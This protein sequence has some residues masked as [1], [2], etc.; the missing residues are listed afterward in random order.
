MNHKIR[1][2]LMLFVDAVLINLAVYVALLLRF[3]GV[4]PGQYVD[5]FV[6]LMPVITITILVFFT[7][8]KMY[9]RIWEYA[10]I[11]E[12][13]AILRATTY[14]IAFIILLI[15]LLQLPK[16]PRSVYIISWMLIN[17]F[18]GASRI[19]WR[20]FRDAYLQTR[21]APS[22]RVL[23]I[24]AGDAGAILAREIASNP[25]LNLKVAGFIDDDP[26]KQKNILNGLPVLGTRKS[27]PFLVRDLEISEV[28]IAMPSVGSDAI[29]EIV[30]LCKE[31]SARI[32]ILPGIYQSTSKSLLT[33]LRDIK[34]ED[35]L[36]REQVTVDITQIA[37]YISAKTVLVTGA[38]G[39]IGSE[40]CRQI[41]EHSP[42]LLIMVDH[43][44]NN[45]FEIE[46]ELHD[47]YPASIIYP[48][49]LDIR[50]QSKLEEIF[51]QYR[52]KIVFHAAAFKHV[53]MME[54]HPTEA[55]S[56]NV[57][58]TRNLA[59]LADSYG[60]ESFVLI[61]TDKAVN[62][63]SIMGASKRLAEL[64]IKDVNRTSNTRFSAVRFGNVL[65]SRGSVI[66]T[67]MK[68]IERGGPVTVT[69][70]E[71]K[72]YFMTI[73]EA[74]QLVIQA[75]AIS[76]GGEIFV[77][78]MGEPVKIEDLA[79]DLIRLSGYEAGKDIDI[80]YTGIRPGEK[81]CEELFTSREEMA[82]TSHKKIFICQK[83][84]DRDYVNISKKVDTLAEKYAENGSDV[85]NLMREI[86][87]EYKK[88]AD[89]ASLQKKREVASGRAA[90]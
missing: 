85:F 16:L 86:I 64:V 8:L 62:P 10:S 26:A 31:T 50:N 55:L 29:R 12:M 47:T 58:G 27:I 70:P 66:P 33:A 71:M 74:V 56:N 1:Y 80:V 38:G 54:L 21:S 49:L 82:S 13:L 60:V 28:I 89:N 78:D 14:S 3:D 79:R 42:Q 4:I 90:G 68:Q 30:K 7:G 17:A 48:A 41:L 24:G 46:Q 73:P 76:Q 87:P 45:L 22:R 53:P 83:E 72:R 75:G 88:A 39:S 19:S 40:L 67:F 36:R 63:T 2:I 52:P 57:I 11:G 77:L 6:K 69:H 15:Y 37:G 59:R 51:R 23:I 34:M 18:I 25:R 65:G 9:R 61:S 43:S 35:L 84:L 44:E 5:A 81:L 20:L 32:R